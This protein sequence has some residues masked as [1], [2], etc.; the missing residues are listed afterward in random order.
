MLYNHDILEYS[1]IMKHSNFYESKWNRI[2]EEWIRLR[3]GDNI[4]EN[5]KKLLER[6]IGREYGKKKRIFFLSKK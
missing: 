4:Q 6:M 2:K 3:W 1:N 5:V